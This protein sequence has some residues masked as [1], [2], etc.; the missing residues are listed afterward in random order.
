[1]IFLDQYGFGEILAMVFAAANADCVFFQGPQ[2]GRC[3]SRVQ[4]FG[5]GAF[6]RADEF[7]RER[8]DP[9]QPLQKI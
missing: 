3:L 9:A 8:R 1:M 6:N 5:A 4:N 2:A 7:A